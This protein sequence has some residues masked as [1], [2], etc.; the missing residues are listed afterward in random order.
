LSG[1]FV[2]WMKIVRTQLRRG[3][4][5]KIIWCLIGLFLVLKITELGLNLWVRQ[6]LP[7]SLIETTDLDTRIEAKVE[8]LSLA[9]FM[10]G[11]IRSIQLRGFQ[12]RISGVKL[13]QL[14]VDSDGFTLDLNVLLKE[15]QF[16]FKKIAHTVIQAQ[17]DET[18]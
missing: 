13:K 11:R 18:P 8:W 4:K 16:L 9:D 15:K 1:F 2:D 10:A 12:C 3:R 5:T 7:Q 6:A 14:Q 17:V